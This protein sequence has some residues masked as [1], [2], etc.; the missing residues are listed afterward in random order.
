MKLAIAAT[1]YIISLR[2]GRS[3]DVYPRH[4]HTVGMY[5]GFSGHDSLARRVKD[6]H[7]WRALTGN[8][9]MPAHILPMDR[10]F[11]LDVPLLSQPKAKDKP[12]DEICANLLYFRTGRIFARLYQTGSH[13]GCM[14]G[15]GCVDKNYGP[16][17]VDDFDRVIGHLFISSYSGTV[18]ISQEATST[19]SAPNAS[20][21]CLSAWKT[22][23][24]SREAQTS[25]ASSTMYSG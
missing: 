1:R 15:P 4:Y 23:L 16:Y 2:G 25:G 3:T 24:L 8:L 18:C 11:I 9:A 5:R 12:S 20:S 10:A 13:D 17:L 7:Y 22:R 19:D 21:T 14:I 6:V